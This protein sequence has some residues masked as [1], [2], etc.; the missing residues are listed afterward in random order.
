MTS[1]D[2]VGRHASGAVEPAPN[3]HGC[4]DCLLDGLDVRLMVIGDD[5]TRDLAYAAEGLLE[6]RCGGGGIAVFP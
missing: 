6:E 1:L 3:V 2:R 5:G 4:W